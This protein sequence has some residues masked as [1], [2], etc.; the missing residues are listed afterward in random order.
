MVAARM[1]LELLPG[2]SKM[3]RCYRTIQHGNIQRSCYQLVTRGPTI[4]LPSCYHKVASYNYYHRFLLESHSPH[5]IYGKLSFQ[6]IPR[7]IVPAIQNCT[8][9]FHLQ[10]CLFFQAGKYIHQFLYY[11]YYLWVLR[12]ELIFDFALTWY[13]AL[14]LL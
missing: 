12:L 5:G 4:L 8:P 3:V 14:L 1:L 9:A 6:N 13:T 2:G 10:N 11:A 7:E